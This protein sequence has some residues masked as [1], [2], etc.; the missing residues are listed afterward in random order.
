MEPPQN[1]RN[2][3]TPPTHATRGPH[4]RAPTRAED[5]VKFSRRMAVATSLWCCVAQHPGHVH[6]DI[7]Y[8]VVPHTDRHGRVWNDLWVPT[9]GP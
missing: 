8:D 1:T 5:W 4:A 2:T 3:H 7:L 6:Y 9:C